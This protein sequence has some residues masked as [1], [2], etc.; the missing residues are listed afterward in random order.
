MPALRCLVSVIIASLL[1]LLLCSILYIYI[2]RTKSVVKYAHLQGVVVCIDPGHPTEF[3]S[4]MHHV[5]GLR[6]VD[7]NWQVALK[8]RKELESYGLKIILTK[9]KCEKLVSNPRRS[10][11]ANDAGSAL[12][13]RLHCDAGPSQGYTLYYPNKMGYDGHVYGPNKKVRVASRIAAY[14]I[15]SGM[16]HNLKDILKDRGVRGESRTRVGEWKGALRGSVYVKVPVVTIEMVFLNNYHDSQFIRTDSGQ[17]KMAKAIADGI[18]LALNDPG[19]NI[20]EIRNNNK[21]LTPVGTSNS[22]KKIN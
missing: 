2:N 1:S 6:E 4:G 20:R 13:V 10:I 15:H 17:N 22:I 19:T 16:K 8:I 21:V 7:I 11:I 5:R 14:R 18:L 9:D 3:N 12:M